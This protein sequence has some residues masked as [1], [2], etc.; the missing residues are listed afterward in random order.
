MTTKDWI[1]LFVPIVC[2]GILLYITQMYLKRHFDKKDRAR[3]QNNSMYRQLAECLEKTQK[4]LYL[5]THHQFDIYPEQFNECFNDAAFNIHEIQRT[6]DRN[7]AFYS[8][9]SQDLANIFDIW[10]GVTSRLKCV[11]ANQ[12]G[13]LTADDSDFLSKKFHILYETV[14]ALHSSINK[15]IL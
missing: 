9:F 15:R 6:N 14:S 12:N 10:D 13:T 3:E 4:Y 1:I 5:L 2:N 7:V 8:D 11:V